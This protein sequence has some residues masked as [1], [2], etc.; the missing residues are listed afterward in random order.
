MFNYFELMLIGMIW[1]SL[2]DTVV[3][4]GIIGF[5]FEI[6][7][8]FLSAVFCRPIDVLRVNSQVCG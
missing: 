6:V 2:C 8:S 5:V 7:R 4:D 1:S 3:V